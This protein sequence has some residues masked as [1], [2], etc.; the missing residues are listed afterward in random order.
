MDSSLSKTFPQNQEKG[1]RKEKIIIQKQT[2]VRKLLKQGEIERAR[3]EKRQAL[4]GD[5]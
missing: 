5:R 4:E 2:Q 3:G 1:K